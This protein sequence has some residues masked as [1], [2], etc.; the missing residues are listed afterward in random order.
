MALAA[1]I[2]KSIKLGVSLSIP[3]L[4]SAPTTATALGTVNCIAPGRV[5]AGMGTGNSARKSLGLQGL[6]TWKVR[7]HACE[8]QSLLAGEEIV[9]RFNGTERRIRL[10]HRE[11]LRVDPER[12]IPIY[13][14][15]NGPK[16]TQAAA[17]GG[18]GLI[19]GVVSGSAMGDAPEV[20]ADVLATFRTLAKKEIS[21]AVEMTPDLGATP[22]EAVDAGFTHLIARAVGP[23]WDPGWA[24]AGALAGLTSSGAGRSELAAY[25]RAARHAGDD[26]A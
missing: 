20:F 3:G 9:H 23:D 15:T 22:D 10:K 14:A 6:A 16:A 8:V 26:P 11:S 25:D 17:E 13:I 12:P 21:R 1:N 5:W 2:T 7:D 19:S 24:R 4:R 18:D